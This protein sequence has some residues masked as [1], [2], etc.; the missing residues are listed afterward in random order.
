MSWKEKYSSDNPA[1]KAHPGLRFVYSHPAHAI[2]LFF[3]AGSLHPAPGTWGSLAAVFSWILMVAA[4]WPWPVY[5][6][7]IVAFFFLGVWASQ[8][9]MN[10]LGVEDPGCVVIDEVVAVWLLCL[11][12]PQT[13]VSWILA[14][15]FF[16]IFDILKM[17]GAAWFDKNWHNGWGVM[18]D[19]LFAAAWALLVI[20]L[21][22]RI[23]G[24]F[25]FHLLGVF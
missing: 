18:L 20:V 4:H 7:I 3:G 25:S 8:K 1:Q 14:F 16:R 12:L 6:V 23:A 24:A 11:M 22:D 13:T 17:P 15:V 5:A 10:D 9:T 19:D 21:L 2:S